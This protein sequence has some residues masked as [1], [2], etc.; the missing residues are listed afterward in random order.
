MRTITIVSYDEAI[1]LYGFIGH[2]LTIL[3]TT[4]FCVVA[5][6]EYHLYGMQLTLQ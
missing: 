6:L 4:N 2:S 5:L 1:A 3:H